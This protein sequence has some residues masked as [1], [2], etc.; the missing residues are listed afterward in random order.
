MEEIL[1]SNYQENTTQ[2]IFHVYQPIVDMRYGEIFG[3]EAL[4]RS[5]DYGVKELFSNA[6][7]NNQLFKFDTHSINKAL[8]EMNKFLNCNFFIN[9]FPSTVIDSDFLSIIEEIN[10]SKNI[11]NNQIVF[12][13]NEDYHEHEL[14]SQPILKETIKKIKELGFKFALDDIGTEAAS[15]KNLIEYDPD[16]IKLDRYF[17]KSLS[18]SLEKQRIVKLLAQ[19]KSYHSKLVLEGIETKEDFLTAKKLG[20]D[21]GQG[22]YISKPLQLVN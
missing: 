13:L 5:K 12:E 1:T 15:F 16:F 8:I 20:V 9:I 22:F 10:S 4:L 3:Y 2:N 7:K 14:W 21:L 6:R 18:S 11:I 19:F 17:A